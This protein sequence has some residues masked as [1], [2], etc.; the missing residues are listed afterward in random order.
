MGSSERH[1][2]KKIVVGGFKEPELFNNQ[3]TGSIL[4]RLA[5]I[6]YYDWTFTICFFIW[7]INNL[8]PLIFYFD[9]FKVKRD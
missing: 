4:W 7:Q 6:Q 8:H 9:V 5:I 2:D 3:F 1:A